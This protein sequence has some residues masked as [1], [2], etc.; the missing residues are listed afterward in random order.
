MSPEQCDADPIDLDTRSDVYA[1]GVVLYELL[2]RKLP[3]D[4]SRAAV[5]E[6]ARMIRE[7]PPVRPSAVDRLLR[8]DVETIT[9][10]AMEK[11]RER[12]YQSAADLAQD[13]RRY[14]RTE[15]I[16]ARPPSL[17]YHL[18]KVLARH[19]R[20]LG[21]IAS[22]FVLIAVVGYAGMRYVQ[23][24][25]RARLAAELLLEGEEAIRRG[26]YESVED[27]L[28]VRALASTVVS[29]DFEATPLAGALEV[30]AREVGVGIDVDWGALAPITPETPVTLTLRS[31]TAVSALQAVL[32]VTRSRAT[33]RPAAV[34]VL[35][36][37]ILVT[38]EQAVRD[39]LQRV[40]YDTESIVS[41][42]EG[43]TRQQRVDR[44]TR[45]LMESVDP[46]EWVDW[47]GRGI[48]G[49]RWMD[50]S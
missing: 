41:A 28:A 16:E 3:Y 4:V 34:D 24:E 20:P 8:G 21:A 25:R 7:S 5:Y 10:K 1:L 29:L 2:C 45:I 39:R 35:D 19:R 47:G 27:R 14:L 48:A 11:E 23:N 38:S 17:G 22:A 49:L 30:I 6:A 44:L 32:L 31:A 36:G 42:M 15:P 46:E 50:A 37:A 13:I 12:R 9:L 18:R 33:D 26:E 40:P 43:E